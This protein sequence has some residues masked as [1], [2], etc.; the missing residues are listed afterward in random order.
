M[1][2]SLDIVN[3]VNRQ[4]SSFVDR[5]L[6]MRSDGSVRAALRDGDQQALAPRA[7]PYL[8]PWFNS[9]ADLDAALLFG[10]VIAGNYTIRYRADMPFGRELYRAVS[11][12]Q[13]SNQAAS[14][15]VA[16]QR[17]PLPLAHRTLKSLFTSLD[18]TRSAS[19]DWDSVWRMYRTWDCADLERQQR[20]R[21]R[22]LLDFYGSAISTD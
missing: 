11:A 10:S 20:T 8:A 13:L 15:L 7:L 2:N 1:T 4:P 14:R 16:V 22:L 9:E 12:G 3:K 17:Q 18:R 6:K 21:R 5:L 19:L